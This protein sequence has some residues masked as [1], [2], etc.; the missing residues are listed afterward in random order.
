MKILLITDLY[1]IKSCENTTPKTLLNF[2]TEWQKNG[3]SV[4]I[5]KP[6]FILNSFLRNKP[7]YKTLKYGNILNIN[8]WTPFWFDIKNKI[9][10]YNIDFK[11]YDVII[12]HMPSGIL[13]ADKLNLPF[14]AG[15]HN[16]DLQVLTKKLYKIHFAKRLKEALKNSKNVACRSYVIKNKLLNI[17]PD[18]KDKTFTA[19]SGID[20][21][22]VNESSAIKHF[23]SSTLKILTC[24][25]LKKRKNIDKVIVACKDIPNIQLTVIG[26]GKIRKTLQKLDKNVIFTGYLNNEE[27]IKKMKDNDIF[28]LPSTNETFGMV[29]LEAM[30]QGCITVCSENDGIA[31]IIKDKFNG[32]LVKPNTENIKNLLIEIKNTDVAILNNISFNAFKTAENMTQKKCAENYLQQILKIS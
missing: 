21:R 28:I 5:I 29:Y 14:T 26:E 11:S 10:K 17:L 32:F 3:H 18:L 7:F 19:P 9:K 12:A 15:V 6:N 4:D 30:S 2:V 25:H 23:K 20:E 27:V 24:A 22:I 16:S 31:G 8:Y 1:P 13:F